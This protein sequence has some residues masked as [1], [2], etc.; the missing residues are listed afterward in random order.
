MGEKLLDH[1]EEMEI[2]KCKSGV[3]LELFRP[4]LLALVEQ[5]LKVELRPRQKLLEYIVV[6]VVLEKK[7]VVGS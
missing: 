3:V 6:G 4:V 1:Q 2:L 5:A 7:L